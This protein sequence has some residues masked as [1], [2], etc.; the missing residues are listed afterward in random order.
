MTLWYYY[1]LTIILLFDNY[2]DII[3]DIMYDLMTDDILIWYC[4][5][6]GVCGIVY[7]YGMILLLLMYLTLLLLNDVLIVLLLLCV[8]DMWSY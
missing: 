3:I 4:V 6:D 1:W 5:N 2:C 7:Y 8:V